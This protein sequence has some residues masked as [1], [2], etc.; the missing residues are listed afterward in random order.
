MGKAPS[1]LYGIIEKGDDEGLEPPVVPRRGFLSFLRGRLSNPLSLLACL[2]PSTQMPRSAEGLRA[3][4]AGILAEPTVRIEEC[5][6][7]NGRNP[8]RSAFLARR[9]ES[10][11]RRNS[12]LRSAGWRTDRAGSA[13][14]S[15]R[16]GKHGFR[17]SCRTW[18]SLRNCGKE[19]ASTWTSLSIGPCEFRW[20]HRRCGPP[21]IGEV[22]RVDAG[23]EHMAFIGDPPRGMRGSS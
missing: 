4:L 1:F 12:A 13:W 9:Q 2:G 7:Q 22:R 6:A 8:R 15:A 10:L 11:S 19:S 16:W 5:V 20:I 17:H 21:V 3:F 18:P 23:L 14:P